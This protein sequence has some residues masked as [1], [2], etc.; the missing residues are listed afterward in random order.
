MKINR[1]TLT[2]ISF[3]VITA[4]LMAC[5]PRQAV[6]SGKIAVTV[7]ILPQKYFVERI[8]G[9]L[10]DVNVM[11]GPGE[12]PHTF[13]PQ[14]SQMEALSNSQIYFT[15]G[16]E[17]EDAWLAKFK[18]ANPEMKFV[19]TSAGIAKIPMTAEEHHDE[20]AE[21]AHEL[22]ELDPHIWLSPANVKVI[23]QTI[24]TALSD[25]DPQNS[26]SY[27]EN[28]NAFLADVD[29]LDQEIRSSLDTLSTR[30]FI[31]FHPAWGYF[32][33]DYD[34][35]QITIEI[36]GNEPSASELAT[37]ISYAKEND[38]HFIFAEPEFSTK[39]AETIANEINGQV[40]LIDPLA[41]DWLENIK[42]VAQSLSNTLQ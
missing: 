39:S 24:A 30:Q 32:A 35:E 28:L 18:D 19:D 23:A 36:G 34:L 15:I 20:D 2:F 8:G 41:E 26:S 10:V 6:D 13:E 1:K 31:T 16:V 5:S 42:N 38:I 25:N 40:I 22:G 27:Q 21:T 11:V 7:S 4:A 37:L 17:F 14:P 33:Q 3:L 29:N 9:D 12:E